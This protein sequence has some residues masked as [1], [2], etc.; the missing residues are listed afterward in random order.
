MPAKRPASKT[1]SSTRTSLGVV[2]HGCATDER[3]S[4]FLNAKP[5]RRARRKQGNPMPFNNSDTVPGD[6]AFLQSEAK[7][8]VVCAVRDN[9]ANFA[10][11]QA[12]I[13][14]LSPQ[15]MKHD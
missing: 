13:P 3:G 12:I 2:G 15:G 10:L 14:H 1:D 7:M 11:V 8:R 6:S 9:N 5:H 4:A